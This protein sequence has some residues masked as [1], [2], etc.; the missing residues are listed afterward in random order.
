MK[1]K[2]SPL[3]ALETLGGGIRLVLVIAGLL[4]LLSGCSSTGGKDSA[5]GNPPDLSDVP[6]AVPKVEPKSKYGN[7]K[8]YV[9]FGKRYHTKPSSEGHVEQGLASWYGKK[10]HGRKTSSGERYDMYA[11]TAAHKSLPLPTY[12]RV[13]NLKNGRSA[14]VKINDRGPFHGKRIIDLSY[15]AAHKLGVVSKGTA[16][17]E[18]QA[19]DPRRPDIDRREHNLFV[20]SD[21][22][23]ATGSSRASEPVLVTENR[24]ST[25][26]RRNASSQSV[27]L[28]AQK[29]EPAE[30]KPSSSP[31]KAP[32]RV[33]RPDTASTPDP[34]VATASEEAA[35]ARSAGSILYLQVGAFGERTNAE[36]L[37]RQLVDQLAEQ[38]QVRTG[39]GGKAALYKVRVGPFDSRQK[40]HKVSEQL[41]SLGLTQS[42]VVRE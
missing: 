23:S 13:T 3:T 32:I 16:L 35:S 30:K 6:D 24:T 40:A 10:F 41:A 42:H 21:G 2:Q 7:P 38:V 17:V 5:P 8:S 9:V 36:Q 27:G 1:E 4:A 26:T 31:D 22:D 34:K 29:A 33:A 20:D 14:V 12:A 19:I 11:M 28:V 39:D 37:R 18:V 15:A 25:E